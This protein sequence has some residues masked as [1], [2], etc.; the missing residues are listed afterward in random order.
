MSVKKSD[1]NFFLALHHH[2]CHVMPL[3]HLD[4]WVKVF[5]HTCTFMDR[6]MLPFIPSRFKTSNFLIDT[7]WGFTHYLRLGS[8]PVKKKKMPQGHSTLKTVVE[9]NIKRKVAIVR[10]LNFKDTKINGS[11]NRRTHDG[12]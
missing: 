12:K 11:M 1:P 5:F 10:T 7:D 3:T 6:N 9:S 8:N 4:Q 2:L